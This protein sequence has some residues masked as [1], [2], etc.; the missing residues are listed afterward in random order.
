M[1]RLTERA[2]GAPG[3]AAR[4]PA[5][6]VRRFGSAARGDT[7]GARSP[8]HSDVGLR[9]VTSAQVADAEQ[10]EL[11]GDT[12]PGYLECGREISPHFFG[13]LRLAAPESDRPRELLRQIEPEA[14]GMW[15]RD[16]VGIA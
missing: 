2:G 1:A 5:G 8:R 7:S 12:Y 13:E 15:P 6:G 9:A 4:R 14:A 11:V 10:D 16:R 3:A